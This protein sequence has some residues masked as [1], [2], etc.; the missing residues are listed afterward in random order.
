MTKSSSPNLAARRSVRA[1]EAKSITG[2]VV[3]QRRE[4]TPRLEV[5]EQLLQGFALAVLVLPV[6]DLSEVQVFLS[7]AGQSLTASSRQTGKRTVSCSRSQ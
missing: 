3:C 6:G 7:S 4:F 1:S 2:R 5:L